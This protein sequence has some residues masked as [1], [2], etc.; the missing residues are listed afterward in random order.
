M[1]VLHGT[2]DEQIPA[3]SARSVVDRLCEVSDSVDLRILPGADHAEALDQGRLREAAAWI[4]E[5]LNRASPS[6]QCAT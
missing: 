1:L 5:R 6:N 2:L 3:D 4:V